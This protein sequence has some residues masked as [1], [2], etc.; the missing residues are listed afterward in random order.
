MTFTKSAR[1][2]TTLPEMNYKELRTQD[3]TASLSE[4]A[5]TKKKKPPAHLI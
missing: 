5:P 4:M 1:H 2:T 3:E